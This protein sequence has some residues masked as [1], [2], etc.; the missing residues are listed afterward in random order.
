MIRL[1]TGSEASGCEASLRAAKTS[2]VPLNRYHLLE[3]NG[4]LMILGS[5]HT[6]RPTHAGVSGHRTTVSPLFFIAYPQTRVPA[7]SLLNP[8]FDCS[9]PILI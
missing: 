8:L 6:T 4:L 2:P 7:P 1:A 3:D 5:R 9:N